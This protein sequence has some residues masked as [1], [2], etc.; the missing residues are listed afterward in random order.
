M[1]IK[2]LT[3]LIKSKSPDSIKTEGLYTLKDKTIAVDA[4]ILIYKSL[5][6]VRNGQ[7]YL[8][9]KEGK[10]VSHILGLFYKVILFKSFNINP[11]FVFDGKPP[12]EKKQVLIERNKK[13][14]ESKALM[15]QTDSIEEKQ[16]LEKS[17]IR[18]NQGHIEDLKKLFDLMGVQY[19]HPNCEAETYAS[20]LCKEKIAYGVYSEDMDTLA[21]G[22]PYLIRNCIDRSIKRKDV[23]SI[24]CLDKILQD[25]NMTYEQF[26][27]VCILC[28]CDYCGTIPKIGSVRAYQSIQKYQS[29]DKF[30]PTI[31]PNILPENY[32]EQFNKAK[33]LFIDYHFNNYKIMNV[34][35]NGN[36]D[37]LVSFLVNECNMS[38]NRVQNALKKINKLI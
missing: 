32:I 28:G 18:I 4:S 22:S 21:F 14:S 29:S 36:Q 2:N 33:S 20:Y 25:F 16:K 19:V 15:E 6:N 7:S 30:F 10:I 17:T 5:T 38:M 9:N 1:G 23:V 3:S 37:K 11:I 8:T 35:N 12:E 31:D 27:E 26:V 24:F 34:N 13:A